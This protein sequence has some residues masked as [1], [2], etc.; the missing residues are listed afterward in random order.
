MSELK[1]FN[2]FEIPVFFDSP[3]SFCLYIWCHL[4]TESGPS[5]R[6]PPTRGTGA[7]APPPAAYHNHCQLSRRI[8]MAATSYRSV[9]VTGPIYIF[10]NGN[11]ITLFLHIPDNQGYVTVGPTTHL[12]GSYTYKTRQCLTFK[13]RGIHNATPF[14]RT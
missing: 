2:N 5:W 10:S 3:C 4:P 13:D 8:Q 14:F 11:K 12:L 9:A 1:Q 7:T 6:P